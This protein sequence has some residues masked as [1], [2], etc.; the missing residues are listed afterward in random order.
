MMFESSD[1]DLSHDANALAM[2]YLTD[3]QLSALALHQGSP[4]RPNRRHPCLDRIANDVKSDISLCGI[5]SNYMSFATRKYLE[6]YGLIS[7][8]E[9]VEEKREDAPV[10]RDHPALAN[11]QQYLRKLNDRS[12][13]GSLSSQSD[14]KGHTGDSSCCDD[15]LKHPH[16]RAKYHSDGESISSE[17]TSSTHSH[18]SG[19]TAGEFNQTPKRTGTKHKRT[20]HN[21]SPPK[22]QQQEFEMPSDSPVAGARVLDIE[23]LKKLPKLL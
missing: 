14:D 19:P 18:P 13:N 12:L 4:G 1:S 22:Y 11:V 8:G 6:R 2:K 9:V 10:L 5:S 15:R 21:I 17:Y 7:G 3:E 23:R 16:E 20:P